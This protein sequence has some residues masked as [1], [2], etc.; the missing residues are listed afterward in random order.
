MYSGSCGC[1]EISFTLAAKPSKLT[2]CFCSDCRKFSSF[3]GQLAAL[4]QAADFKLNDPKGYLK[5]HVVTTT[6]SGLP[7]RRFLCGN[8][9]SS[10]YTI[11]RGHEGELVR[12][13][14][15]LLDGDFNDYMEGVPVNAIFTEELEKF[16]VKDVKLI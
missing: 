3:F 4:H 16:Q 11:P 9:G 8:C 1:R 15:T 10:I 6:R 2:K 5:V 13:R 14:P 12:I 7:K